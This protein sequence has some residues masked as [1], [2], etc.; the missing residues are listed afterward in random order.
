MEDWEFIGRNVSSE[1][2][3]PAT[4]AR[5]Q[6]ERL[7][8]TIEQRYA[9]WRARVSEERALA[10]EPNLS[11]AREQKRPVHASSH[12]TVSSRHSQSAHDGDTDTAARRHHSHGDQGVHRGADSTPSSSHG[13]DRDHAHSSS[14]SSTA[15]AGRAKGASAARA[16]TKERDGHGRKT[17]KH[18]AKGKT[19]K[20]S[21]SPEVKER[22][23]QSPRANKP[24]R[25][26]STSASASGS[27]SSARA[28]PSPSSF[29]STGLG[30]S[31]VRRGSGNVPVSGNGSGS[32]SVSSSS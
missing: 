25:R 22:Q 4:L 26:A 27:L 30:G 12:K 24:V 6:S 18:G 7:D 10:G 5:K 14:T 21:G 13:R 16:R 15:A 19:V 32:G 17:S 29:S 2:Y 9:V 8:V 20:F 11:P 23:A 28:R 3:L 31:T 1:R